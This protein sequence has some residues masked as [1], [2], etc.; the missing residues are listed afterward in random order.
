MRIAKVAEFF[1]TTAT[2]VIAIAIP[3]SPLACASISTYLFRL[4]APPGHYRPW[5]IV[6][7]IVLVVVIFI[8]VVIV[9]VI[10][11]LVIGIVLVVVAVFVKSVI[12][13]DISHLSP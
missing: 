3:Q 10:V 5:F 13:N 1:A 4:L 6:I 11:K 2:L 12:A 9:V 8:C 7:V